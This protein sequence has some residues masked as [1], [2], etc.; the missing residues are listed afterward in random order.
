VFL[1]QKDSYN[2]EKK[3][4]LLSRKGEPVGLMKE[5]FK[6]DLNAFVK[7]LNPC[8]NWDNQSDDDRDGFWKRMD[9]EYEYAGGKEKLC[10]KYFREKISRAISRC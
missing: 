6:K 7:R 5:V 8:C 2:D 1:R 4:L 9:A 3:R 10:E